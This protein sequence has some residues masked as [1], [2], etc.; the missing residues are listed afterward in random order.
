MGKTPQKTGQ[1]GIIMIMLIFGLLM[2]VSTAYMKMVQTEVE[3]QGMVDNSDRAMDAAFSGISYAIAIAQ[4]NNSMFI[5]NVDAVASRT[6]I[7]SFASSTWGPVQIPSGITW[8]NAKVRTLVASV[9]SD[10]MFLNE[11]LNNYTMDSQSA[12]P[13][14]FFRVNSYPATGTTAVATTA[15]L[16]IKSQGR[17]YN[18]SDNSKT[19]I[20]AT[21]SAQ[22]IAECKVIFER[23]ILQLSRYRFMPFQ[24]NT[25]FFKYSPY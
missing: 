19:T 17:Y 10:W 4:S 1:A 7:T 14:Y 9:P 22:L 6:Y 8:N 5:N 12:S 11:T 15:I 13:P 24:N 23:K 21:Y 2:T 3:V 20:I 16:L 18:Y 25:E